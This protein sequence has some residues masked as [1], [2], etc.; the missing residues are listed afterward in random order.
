ML[1]ISDHWLLGGV[2]LPDN[3]RVILA[4]E[5]LTKGATVKGKRRKYS[6]SEKAAARAEFK[7]QVTESPNSLK[8][9]RHD[10]SLVTGGMFFGPLLA[11]FAVFGYTSRRYWESIGIG[12]VAGNS[13][14]GRSVPPHEDLADEY[15]VIIHPAVY[16]RAPDF[17]TI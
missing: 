17:T 12:C 4:S 14:V 8:S 9:E 13:L 16:G 6:R 7:A 11:F 10:L 3:L 5:N 1:T 2:H 15:F